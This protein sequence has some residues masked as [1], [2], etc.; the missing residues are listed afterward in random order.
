MVTSILERD[1]AVEEVSL[2]LSGGVQRTLE[3]I[4]RAP[5]TSAELVAL[6]CIKLITDPDS[7]LLSGRSVDLDHDVDRVL[8]DLWMGRDGECVKRNWYRLK[9]EALP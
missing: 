9:I 8:D 2:R 1:G 5:T 6:A 7:R 3:R 4:R